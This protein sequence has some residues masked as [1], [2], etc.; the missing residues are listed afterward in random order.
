MGSDVARRDGGPGAEAHAPGRV[1][2]AVC[3]HDFA[4]L[5]PPPRWNADMEVLKLRTGSARRWKLLPLTTI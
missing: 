1:R 3:R 2:D 5:A 4:E